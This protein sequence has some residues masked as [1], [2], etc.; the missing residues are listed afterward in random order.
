VGRSGSVGLNWPN[1]FINRRPAL[2]SRYT[3]KY[4]HQ[5]AQYEDPEVIGGWFRLI[6]NTIAKYGIQDNNIWNFDETSFAMGIAST[7][8]VVTTSDRR[9]RPPLLQPGDRE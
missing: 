4:D 7:S 6:Q 1:R 8:R 5:R 2:A 9:G 3:R